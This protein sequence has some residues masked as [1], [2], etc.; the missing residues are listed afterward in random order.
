MGGDRMLLRDVDVCNDGRM[1][2][3]GAVILRV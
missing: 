3:T 2:A 1:P